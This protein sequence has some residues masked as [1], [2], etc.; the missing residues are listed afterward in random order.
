MFTSLEDWT[1]FPSVQSS[2]FFDMP[3]MM[4]FGLDLGVRYRGEYVRFHSFVYN[5]G[6]SIVQ[7]KSYQRNS[8]GLS[9]LDLIRKWRK[10]EATSAFLACACRT[11]K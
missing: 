6:V 5:R 3:S 11:E 7:S 8:E 9:A 2:P 4:R 10:G 1:L